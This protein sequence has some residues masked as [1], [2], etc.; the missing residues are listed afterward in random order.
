MSIGENEKMLQDM[1]NI[2]RTYGSEFSLSLNSNKCGVLICNKP[3]KGIYDFKLG[4]QIIKRIREYEYLG[5]LFK[6]GIQGKPN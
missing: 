2:M 6:G 1:L 5:L 3:E 4:N